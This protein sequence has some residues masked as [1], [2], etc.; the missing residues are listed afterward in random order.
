MSFWLLARR[1]C[2]V[3]PVESG[4]KSAVP[5]G[6]SWCFAHNWPVTDCRFVLGRYKKPVCTCA[7]VRVCA[8]TKPSVSLRGCDS[9]RCERQSCGVFPPSAACKSTQPNLEH[10]TIFHFHLT[11]A[12]ATSGSPQRARRAFPEMLIRHQAITSQ[13]SHRSMSNQSCLEKKQRI[14]QTIY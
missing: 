6:S 10:T 14:S 8:C 4:L 13:V 9:S 7:S 3:V 5:H 2:W 11:A 12:A 1:T